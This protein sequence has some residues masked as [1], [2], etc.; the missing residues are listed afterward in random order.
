MTL[1]VRNLAAEVS[2]KEEMLAVLAEHSAEDPAESSTAP[3]LRTHPTA[4]AERLPDAH[5]AE[6]KMAR[7][8]RGRL[9]V[10]VSNI[11]ASS[12]INGS[13]M[14]GYKGSHQHS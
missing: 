10:K 3:Q 14:L 6:T 7:R 9:G 1:R 11:Y 4:G 2:Q 5:A 12:L 8:S 13:H